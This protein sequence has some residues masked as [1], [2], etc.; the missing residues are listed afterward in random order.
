M[1]GISFSLWSALVYIV[2][3]GGCFM[4]LFFS[5]SLFCAIVLSHEVQN[6]AIESRV[7][8]DDLPQLES[9]RARIVLLCA[10]GIKV[11]MFRSEN[12]A[13]QTSGRATSG[14]LR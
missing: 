3:V 5:P 8:L 1:N 12:V 6:G 11:I 10:E 14:A 2:K 7:D 9:F 13:D 4:G